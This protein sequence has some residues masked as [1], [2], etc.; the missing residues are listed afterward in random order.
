MKINFCCIL[1]IFVLSKVELILSAQIVEARNTA[2]MCITFK[3]ILPVSDLIFSLYVF[4]LTFVIRL[5][6]Q[7]ILDVHDWNSCKILKE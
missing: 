7:L 5:F 6:I 2:Y 1:L 4:N 3:T